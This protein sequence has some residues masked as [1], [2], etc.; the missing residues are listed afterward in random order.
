MFHSDLAPQNTR[1]R[2]A[3]GFWVGYPVR[4]PSGRAL[5]DTG[6]YWTSSN[7]S[8]H[9][10]TKTKLQS[11]NAQASDRFPLC[12]HAIAPLDHSRQQC[13]PGRSQRRDS[14]GGAASPSLD[15][16]R[17]GHAPDCLLRRECA[18]SRRAH[19][20]IVQERGLRRHRIQERVR[21]QRLQRRPVR[22]CRRRAD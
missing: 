7:P 16:F 15:T 20:G 17:Q 1:S 2:S 13:P 21:R 19:C 9:Y 11:L 12:R 5:V 8:F 10:S 4:S 3:G 18:L 6:R 14:Q 22:S